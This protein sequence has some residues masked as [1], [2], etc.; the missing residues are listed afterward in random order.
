MSYDKSFVDQVWLLKMVGCWLCSL[1]VFLW[2]STSS[3]SMKMQ[4]E[5]L[6]NIQPF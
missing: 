5:N 1:F 2:S 4:K 6:A 3:K